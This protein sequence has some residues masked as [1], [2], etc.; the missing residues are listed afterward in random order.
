MVITLSC[1]GPLHSVRLEGALLLWDE[2][3]GDSRA[4]VCPVPICS[5]VPKFRTIAVFW[6]LTSVRCSK[7]SPLPLQKGTDNHLADCEKNTNIPLKHL[8]KCHQCWS[9]LFPTPPPTPYVG[10]RESY[11]SLRLLLPL[12]NETAPSDFC[13]QNDFDAPSVLL[14]LASYIKE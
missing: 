3:V 2:L 8:G 12:Q 4:G 10:L 1:P 5:G 7:H 11:C 14:G 13:D 9:F 6:P